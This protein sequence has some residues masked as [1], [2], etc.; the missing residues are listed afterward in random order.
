MDDLWAELDTLFADRHTW[1]GEGAAGPRQMLAFM[2]CY[3]LDR[4]RQYLNDQ[5]LLNRF[6][7]DKSRRRL[8]ERDDE[9]LLRFGFD[10]LL[11]LLDGRPTLQAKS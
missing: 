7:L 2:V 4:F 9:A 10:W 11:H 8:I 3:N 6:R 1:R 5:Q